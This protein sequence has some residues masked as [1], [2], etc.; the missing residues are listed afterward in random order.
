MTHPGPVI[1]EH[2]PLSKTLPIALLFN[3]AVTQPLYE[4]LSRNAQFFVARG[5]EPVDIFVLVLVLSFL[6]PASLLFV[7][8]GLKKVSRIA[9]EVVYG[10]LFILLT[11]L[12]ILPLLKKVEILPGWF[13]LASSLFLGCSLFWVTK[14]FQTL[15]LFL[16]YLSVSI[17]VFAAI[18]LMNPSI[19][20]ILTSKQ[21]ESMALTKISSTTPV[22]FVI[23]DELPLISLLTKDREIDSV[24]FPNFSRL[25]KDSLW[26]RNTSTVADGT[27]EAVAAILTGKYPEQRRLPALKD[28]PNNLFTLLGGSYELRVLEH[29]TKLCPENVNVAGE[30]KM[31]A[32]ERFRNLY[33]DLSVIYLHI[34]LPMELTADLPSVK[35]TWSNFWQQSTSGN[36]LVRLDDAYSSRVEQFKKFLELL[37]PSTKPALYFQHIFLPHVPWE[38]LPSGNR[39]DYR[40]YGPMGIEGISVKEENWLDDDC[41]VF[42]GYQRHLLQLGFTDRKL[43]ELIEHLKSVQLYD[44]ALIVITADHGASFRPGDSF[45]SLSGSNYQDILN[46]PLF[47]KL[48]SSARVAIIDRNVESIDILPTIADALGIKLG[49]ETDG[50]SALQDG[51]QQRNKKRAYKTIFTSDKKWEEFDSSIVN[52]ASLARKIAIFGTGNPDQILQPTMIPQLVKMSA[53]DPS[54]RSNDRVTIELK[55]PQSFANV[56]LTSGFIPVFIAGRVLFPVTPKGPILLGVWINGRFC[57]ITSTFP[58]DLKE[59]GWL[60]TLWIRSSTGKTQNL[61]MEDIQGFGILVAESSFRQGKNDIQ[62]VNLQSWAEKNNYLPP[63]RLGS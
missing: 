20:K 21:P 40:G 8:Y 4:L 37:Q 58:P 23:L 18:F 1:K 10:I 19:S 42:R 54:F 14:R 15:N 22:V 3:L 32:S 39:Y 17:F 35:H 38:Y 13:I 61:K 55:N 50:S 46:V 33:L 28:Y 59:T 49:F 45:R 51:S 6:I 5:S 43:G 41:I 27:P 7:V 53:T 2:H 31:A 9:G 60:R 34:I 25:Q 52:S 44:R 29:V 48:P 57:G 56:D 36:V 47:V 16:K 30:R 26:F 24:R 11:A 63:W 62:V 12:F